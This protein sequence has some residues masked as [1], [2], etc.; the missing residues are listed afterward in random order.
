MDTMNVAIITAA[1]SGIRMGADTKKQYLVLEGIPILIR[2]LERFFL[3]D[4]IHRVIVTAPEDDVE[5]VMGLIQEYFDN[6]PKPWIVIPGGA[7][8][9]DSVFAALQ[10]CPS[11]TDYVFIH[12]AVR[13]FVTSEL[14]SDLAAIATED[15]A[16][17]P[18]A[19]IK[20]TVKSISGDYIETTVPRDRL[21]QVFTPQV[22]RFGI[23]K[24]AYEKA[25]AEG[26][27]STDDSALVEFCGKKVRYLFSSDLNIKITD[28]TDLFIAA[29][30]IEK[31]I[32]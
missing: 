23:I 7:E 32:L 17:V 11:D 12:D 6:V 2:T 5:Y 29:Q 8:R 25:Y 26:F 24:A 18:V 19:R 31:N 4:V 13:P 14:L 10:A 1:G 16:A 15:G 22:F 20:H 21:V 27:L 28:P 9:Q 30:I 3:S